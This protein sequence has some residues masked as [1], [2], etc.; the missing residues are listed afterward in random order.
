MDQFNKIIIAVDGFAACGKSTLAK[1]LAKSLGYIYIDS[2]A[3]Y[4]AVTLYFLENNIDIKSSDDVATALKN[5]SILFKNIDGQNH[6]FLNN[7]DVENE[8]REMRISNFVSPVSTIS[9]VRRFL[10]ACQKD[11]GQQKGI[12]MDGRDIGTVVFPDAELKLF[13]TASADIRTNRRLLEL[14]TK[15]I[16]E[17]NFE[18]VQKNLLERDHI[19]STRADSPLRK[20]DDA[21]VI[22]NSALSTEEQLKLALDLANE[23]IAKKKFSVEQMN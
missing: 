18:E 19:D 11:M 9:A 5:I 2:G 10:V 6:T 7:K 16:V 8:I 13:M 23:V 21:I 14:Q 4:R 3:M 20:A 1:A 15:G 17:F 12:V 22:D